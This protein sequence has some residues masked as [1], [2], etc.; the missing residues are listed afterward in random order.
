MDAS[1]GEVTQLL[2]AWCSGDAGALARLAPLVESERCRAAGMDRYIAKPI[3]A[4]QLFRALDAVCPEVL[5][6]A[7]AR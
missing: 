1:S 7:Q 5:I 2:N 4:D 3:K 6:P